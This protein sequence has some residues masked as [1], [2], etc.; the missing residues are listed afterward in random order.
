[1]KLTASVALLAC[2][3][4]AAEAARRNEPTLNPVGTWNCVLYGHPAFGDE[5]VLL[6]FAPNGTARL[7]RQQDDALDSWSPLSGW[8]VEDGEMRFSDS[9]TGRRFTA[10]LS[11]ATLGGGW[12]T[13]TAIGGWW[14]NEVD[15]VE[16]Q[17]SG[18]DESVGLMPPLIPQLTA[19]PA[20]PRQAI[21][22]A[23]QGRA[24]T[25]FFVNAEGLIV[26]PELI[27]LSDEIFRA[28][29]LDALQRS[30]YQGWDDSRLVRPACR[31][32]IFKLDAMN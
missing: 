30:R 31:S 12:R 28:P 16:F 8:T 23:K 13:L 20:Y 24:V 14:C 2:I 4:P 27:E 25:C 15:S 29:I 26:E 21:R 10:D 7:A 17:V 19:T 9:R 6:Y 11:R 5:R 3:A 1:V 18:D 32:Y 22:D